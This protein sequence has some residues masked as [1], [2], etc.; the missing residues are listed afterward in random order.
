MTQAQEI[1]SSIYR[2]SELDWDF[3]G[4]K[5]DSPFSD[6]HFH[7]GRFV[8]QIPAALIGSLTEAGD[9]VLDPFC[10]AGTTL[11]E[12]QRLG[13][14][15]IGVDLNPVSCLVS[16]AKTFSIA[17]QEVEAHLMSA[18]GRFTDFRLEGGNASC[19]FSYPP[20]VQLQKW[21]HPETGE[22]L[23]RIWAFIQQERNHIARQLLLFCF[24]SALMACCAETRSWGYVCDNVRPL[25][26]RYVDADAVFHDKVASF[27]DAYRRRDSRR[28]PRKEQPDPFP[29]LVMQGDAATRLTELEDQSIDL[30]V[31]SPPYF[32]V[33]D[34]VKAQRLTL[35]W[36]GLAIEPLRRQETGARSKRHRRTAFDQYMEEL[37]ATVSELHRLLKQGRTLAMIVG[38][39]AKREAVKDRLLQVL[40]AE[41]FE[42]DLTLQ[43]KI[44]L[45]RRQP[46][47][48]VSELLIVATKV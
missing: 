34:Y 19:R 13:R 11:V 16:R 21:Y 20:D 18:L 4:D 37:A 40:Q 35:E 42:S 29:A 47:S 43:R 31:T 23:C 10:G 33:V 24:S 44:G 5:S 28:L 9:C 38:E 7:P 12:A 14:R 32:G 25:E 36:F 3:P 6:L 30:V 45:R 17:A 27:I 39:S 2:L 8:P 46:A 48:L 1:R 41:G 26:R 22:E 15:P